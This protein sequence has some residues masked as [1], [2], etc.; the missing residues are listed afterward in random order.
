[1]LASMQVLTEGDV[2][3][4]VQLARRYEEYVEAAGEVRDQGSTYA[5]EGRDGIQIKTHP[6]VAMRDRAWADFQRG[7]I[8]FGLTPASRSRITPFAPSQDDDPFAA[9]LDSRR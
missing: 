4:L 1:M 3:A 5:S 2:T 6:A 7:L 9:L 8:E